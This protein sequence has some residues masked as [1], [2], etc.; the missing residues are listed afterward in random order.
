ML[1]RWYVWLGLVLLLGFAGS[2]ALICPGRG[3]ITQA[4]FDRIQEGMGVEEVEALLGNDEPD[5][6]KSAITMYR[7]QNGPNRVVVW[8]RNGRAESKHL[9]LATIRETLQWYA[10]KG[11]AKIGVKWD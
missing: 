10:K 7:W 1:R 2:V 9:H 8:F 11:A 3:R 5:G 6:M 4:N